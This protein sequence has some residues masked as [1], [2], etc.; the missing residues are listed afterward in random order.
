MD[1]ASTLTSRSVE[2]TLRPL[3]QVHPSRPRPTPMQRKKVA[4][5][6]AVKRAMDIVI[7]LIVLAALSL[8][9]LVVM[10]SIRLDSKGPVFFLQRR[11]GFRRRPFLLIKFRTLSVIEDGA[12]IAQVLPDDARVTRAG[13]WLRRL[14]IDELP[15]LINVLKGEMSII[16]PRPHAVAH[17][18]QFRA[19]DTRYGRRFAAKPGLTGLAQVSGARGCVVD[20]DALRL[21]TDF[22]LQYIQ[23]WSLW[24]DI[25]ILLRTAV[26]WWRPERDPVLR[27]LLRP[28]LS[29]GGESAFAIPTQLTIAHVITRFIRGGADENTRLSCN[30]QAAAGHRVALIFGR[31]AHEEMLAALDPRVERIRIDALVRRIDP[32]CDALTLMSLV[33]TLRDLKPDIVHTHTSKAGILG[34]LAG[35]IARAKAIVHGVHILPF[36][37]VRRFKRW[38]FLAVER[39]TAPLTDA[40]VSVSPKMQECCL[41]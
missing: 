34:R 22:D 11:G 39:L 7:A 21:R 19:V 14:W 8:P 25:W 3:R 32:V 26:L 40:F 20:D 29:A 17:D 1:V 38:V 15:Q 30:A 2:S 36:L 10:L 13:R 28:S 35:R 4:I 18:A 37:N 23:N 12:H 9:L 27:L 5:G 16:G 33:R 41:A 6:G 24:L 31:E